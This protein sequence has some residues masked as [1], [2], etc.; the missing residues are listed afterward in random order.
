MKQIRVPFITRIKLIGVLQS[1]RAGDGGITKLMA[2]QEVYQAVRF[3]D[4][5]EALL[6]RTE[7]GPPFGTEIKITD[8]GANP[9]ES[10]GVVA[11]LEDEW[12]T[13][14]ARVLEEWVPNAT[15]AD[16]A[17]FTALQAQLSKK[18]EPKMVKRRREE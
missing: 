6:T 13:W 3:R 15:V 7:L 9:P 5:E 8:P 1:A 2:L 4:E 18:T 10:L 14:F 11:E 16:L 17:W 12:A